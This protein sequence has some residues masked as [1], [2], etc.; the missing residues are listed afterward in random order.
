MTVAKFRNPLVLGLVALAGA[1]S[2]CIIDNGSS[3]SGGSGVQADWTISDPT[4]APLSCAQAG[5][6]FVNFFVDG[7]QIDQVPCSSGALSEAVIP[8]THTVRAQLIA[9]NGAI[10]DSVDSTVTVPSCGV[11]TLPT[12]PFALTTC[13]QGAIHASWALS[14]NGQ[15]VS[16]AAGDQ[17]LMT[18]DGANAAFACSDY[19]G[20]TPPVTGGVN[21]N[22][23]L[24][25]I[26]ASN[27]VLSQTQTMALYV[28]C[29]TTED[30]G[31]VPFTLQ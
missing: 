25:L 17:V 1:T 26:D 6:V 21:H 30:I 19:Q 3:C 7:T 8:G 12:I 2:G 16:C 4:G 22:L 13:S 15:S 20:T 10:I 28:H 24:T 23:S 9:S 29:A 18:V 11:T 14:Q 5:A 31:T 27:A